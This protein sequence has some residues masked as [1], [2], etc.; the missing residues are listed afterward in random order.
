MFAAS[1]YS[2]RASLSPYYAPFNGVIYSELCTLLNHDNFSRSLILKGTHE[3]GQDCIM[4]TDSFPAAALTPP[5]LVLLLAA[6]LVRVCGSAQTYVYS[7]TFSVKIW[8]S[9]VVCLRVP[10]A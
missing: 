5:L 8:V 9:I 6:Y 2:N 3:R 1:M 7:T 4:V 10:G